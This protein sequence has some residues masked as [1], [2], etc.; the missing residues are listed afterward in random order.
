MPLI[1]WWLP[2]KVILNCG[3]QKVVSK[4][5]HAFKKGYGAMHAIILFLVNTVYQLSWPHYTLLYVCLDNC[6]S[7]L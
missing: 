3:K 7:F 4:L 1:S 5:M 2:Q 6:P